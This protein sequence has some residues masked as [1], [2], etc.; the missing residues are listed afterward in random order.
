MQR[1]RFDR[2]PAASQS[3]IGRMEDSVFP[4]RA[5]PKNL[6]VALQ[7][8]HAGIVTGAHGNVHAIGGYRLQRWPDI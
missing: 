6:A 1:A 2:M 8:H 3:L 4:M 5:R 7:G